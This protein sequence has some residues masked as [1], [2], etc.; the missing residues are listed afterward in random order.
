M[1]TKLA[2]AGDVPA[3][4]EG[5]NQKTYAQK[6]RA[7]FVSTSKRYLGIFLYLYVVFALFNWHEYIV[8]TQHQI[9]FTHLGFAVVNA[10]VMAK[11]ILVA[12]ELHLGEY[13]QDRPLIYQTLLSSL[14]FA[15]V[16]IAFLAIEH[17]ITGVWRGETFVK[18]IPSFG[19]GGLTGVILVGVI[20]S[21][22]L[23]PFFAL[24]ALRRVIGPQLY[25]LMFR[26]GP[27]DVIV[28]VK[29]PSPDRGGGAVEPPEK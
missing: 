19:G 22:T 29:Y 11:V 25:A 7:R 27:K 5:R 17:V 2:Q 15:I 4:T 1:N 20:L 12:E 28:E 9:G 26:R 18:S 23:I 14:L 21:V 13:L 16:L 24:R 3:E 10:F 6:L 8:L